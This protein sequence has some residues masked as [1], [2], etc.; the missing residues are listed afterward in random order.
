VLP[1]SKHDEV[2]WVFFQVARI[3]VLGMHCSACSTAVETALCARDGVK[4]A[5]VSLSLEMAEVTYDAAVVTEVSIAY[6]GSYVIP[7]TPIACNTL[8]FTP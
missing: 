4:S 6:I 8:A 3:E 7:V 5:S 2:V 1:T